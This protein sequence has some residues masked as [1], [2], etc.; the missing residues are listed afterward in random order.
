MQE[1]KAKIPAKKLTFFGF[2]AMTISMVVSLY[3]YPT[4]ATSGF[5]LVFFLLLGGLLWFIPV[6]L[7]AAEMATVKGWEKGGVYTW[8]SRTLG[9]RFGFAAIFFQWFEIT[10]GYLTML[11]FLTGALSYATGISAIQNNKFLKLAIL[12]IIFWAIL[13]SQL[14]GTKYTSLIARIGFIAG[15]LLPALVLFGLGIHYVD[16]GAPLQTTLSMKTLIPDFSKLPTLVVFVSFILA[17]MGV[18][19]SASHANEMENPKKNYPL[20]MFVLVILAIILDTF[21]GLT[22]ATTVPQQGLSL[23]TGVIQSLEFL[24]RHIDPSLAWIAKILAIL[25]CLGVIGEIASWVTSPSKAL[26]VAAEE[27]LLPAHFAK[28][29]AY[30]VP[31]NL[32]IAN[33]IVASIWATVF[34]LS[35]GGNNLSFLAAMSLTVVIYL[36]L[37]FMFFIG[38]LKLVYKDDSLERAYQ[39]PGGKVVKTIVACLGL[40][41]SLFAFCISFVPPSSIAAGQHGIYETIL[42]I[43]YLIVAVIPFT[44]YACRHKFQHANNK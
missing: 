18:E 8:V 1:S 41:T 32:M 35:G 33:G 34:T 11:Y 17:Y 4:F 42:V 29:N 28:E 3:E 7:C 40:L 13:L 36:M 2:L 38:Y 15:I 9:K 44:I 21:G 30:G 12:L 43:S 6:A 39:V 16:S 14:R 19:T 20:A 23:N 26:H 27:G 24:L 22:V 31:A 10:V 5:S 37:Y 25:V